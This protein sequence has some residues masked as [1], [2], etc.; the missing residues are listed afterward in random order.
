MESKSNP[1]RAELKAISSSLSM[2][3]KEGAIETINQGLKELY[4]N[5][6]HRVLKS[7]REW[8]KEGKS[9]RKGERALLLWGRPKQTVITKAIESGKNEEEILDFFPLAYVFSE[10]QIIQPHEKP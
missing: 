7:F 9:V 2:L 6:G 5:Q 8:K 10:N 4:K 3:K 1:R